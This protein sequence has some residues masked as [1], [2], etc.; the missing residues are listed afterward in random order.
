MK[1]SVDDSASLESSKIFIFY[2]TRKLN[3]MPFKYSKLF[4]PLTKLK[5]SQLKKYVNNG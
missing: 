1:P 3:K 5:E 4:F 2:N